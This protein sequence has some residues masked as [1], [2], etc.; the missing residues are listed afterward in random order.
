MD[1]HTFLYTD[2]IQIKLNTLG[3]ISG[4][5]D[6][7]T[8]T[9][10]LPQSIEAPLITIKIEGK[11]LNPLKLESLKKN[12]QLLIYFSTNTLVEITINTH[13][14]HVT[15]NI[16]KIISEKNIDLLSWGPWPTSINQIIGETVGVVRN[17]AFAIGIQTLNPKTLGGRPL[18]EDD[19]MPS[20]DIF[21]ENSYKDISVEFQDKQLYRGD[22]A[23]ATDYGS[24]LQAYTRDRSLAKNISN[25]GHDE[26]VSP[27]YTDGGIMGSKIALFGCP[28]EELMATLEKIELDEGLP[29]PTIGGQWAKTSP[30]ATESY[31][32][33]DFSEEN[34]NRA[35]A[36]TR[37]AGLKYLYHSAPF[38][39]WGHFVLKK[40]LFPNGY[41][42]F[43][44]CVQAADKKGIYIGFHTL[45]NFT[46]INDT[47]VTPEPD[48][49]LAKIGTTSI[50]SETNIHTQTISIQD[51]TFFRK[52]TTLNAAMIEK[53]IITYNRVSAGPPWK[54]LKCKRGAFGTEASP[55]SRGSD[56]DK[57]LDHPYRVFLSNMDLAQEQ[58][59]RIAHFCNYTGAMQLSFDGLEG[60]W[61]NGYGQYGRTLFTYAWYNALEPR[62]QGRIVN[63]ASN[64]GH[65]N[66]HIYTRMNWGEPW[67][68]G[69]RESQ[70]LYRL[71]NQYYY[72]RNLMPRML[73]WFA[74]REDTSIEDAEWLL[75]RAAG[76]D[77]GFALATSI[78]FNANQVTP[79]KQKGRKKIPSNSYR[80]LE[81]V[82]CWESAR[83]NNVFP[84]DLK[85]QLQDINKE[86]HLEKKG[87]HWALFPIYS[88]KGKIHTRHKFL[89]L[90]NP[91][92]NHSLTLLIENIGASSI[93]ELT[94]RF[95][96]GI[97]LLISPQLNPSQKV[98][99]DTQGN[100]AYYDAKW[101]ILDTNKLDKKWH[102]DCNPKKIILGWSNNKPGQMLKL[103]CRVF[104]KPWLLKKTLIPNGDIQ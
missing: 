62:L 6:K 3:H 8:G 38:Q 82:N 36:A 59:R 23:V 104:G 4:F 71:K 40:D 45:S 86:F 35:I 10:Y 102:L 26:F 43:R 72:S 51:P 95:D 91:Y 31:L 93:T 58:A 92:S 27:S 42:G 68:A 85:E 46:T 20:Y 101:E 77:A 55:H 74:L 33:M 15:F 24:A 60:N 75:A 78:K 63:D 64:P 11:T 69:F 87:D 21:D 73:G 12:S 1:K 84:D 49:R 9:E 76:F 90:Q 94:L 83:R 18:R 19:V 2:Y 66:W 16:S 98:R 14:T 39:T 37:H 96:T 56:I 81:V 28:I 57:L 97:T 61:A 32:I 52:K 34:I 54:L 44:N 30:K 47:Y 99:V 67:Y 5:L 100:I 48:S 7:K 89:P 17:D 88:V 79:T 22:V 103:E 13:R 80:I 50:A 25:W 70:T 53:E 65:F 29:H 41:D